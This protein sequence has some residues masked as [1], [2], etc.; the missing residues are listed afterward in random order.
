MYGYN[1]TLSISKEVC[2]E[3]SIP[4]MVKLAAFV[5][6]NLVRL[7]VCVHSLMALPQEISKFPSYPL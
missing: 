3:V 5:D 1:T 4:T 2:L 6:N 7:C